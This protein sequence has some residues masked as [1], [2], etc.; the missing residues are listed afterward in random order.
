[1]TRRARPTASARR[2][3]PRPEGLMAPPPAVSCFSYLASVRTL[4]VEHYPEIN[5]GVEVLRADQF[6]AGDGPL[7]AGFLRALGHPATL[8]SNQ[9]GADDAGDDVLTWLRR[10]DV[11][12]MP[13]ATAVRRCPAPSPSAPTPAASRTAAATPARPACTAPT[14]N[15]PARSAARPSP[16][17]SPPASWPNT[18]PCSTTRKNS[19]PCSPSSRTSPWRSSRKAA[20][21]RKTAGPQARPQKN[22]GRS[23]LTCGQP[24]SQT[25]YAQVILKRED[26]TR[27]GL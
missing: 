2:C 13:S 24:S 25:P 23:R 10:W 8:A 22:V 5:Y 27:A 4:Y 17:G 1:M 15:G 19:A 12:L 16:A 7:V 21:S 18:S 14:P 6:L 3:A 9:V 26:L 20:G 11:S